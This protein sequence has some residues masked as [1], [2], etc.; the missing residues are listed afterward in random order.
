VAPHPIA[1]GIDDPEF[2]HLVFDA[3]EDG[4]FDGELVLLLHGFPETKRSFRHQLPVLAAL[5]YRV[6]AV[7]QRGYSPS[8][9]PP[10]LDAYRIDKLTGDVL[11]IADSLGADRF[12]LVGHDY[13]AVI[14]WQVAARH[15]GRLLSMTSLSVPHP[16]AYLEAYETS[17]Q[18]ER[19]GYFAWFRDPNTDIELG[20]PQR[21]RQLY[22]AAGLTEDDADAYATALGSPEAIGAALNWYRATGAYMIDG[23]QPITVPVLHVWST[24]DPALGRDGAERTAAHVAGPYR[25]EVLDGVDHWIPENAAD[26]TNRILTDFLTNLR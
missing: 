3:I 5:G 2:E 1:I 24:E 25:F 18:P 4:P 20:D 10:G 11:A 6:V 22:L 12:H 15:Q 8:A 14:A 9:R 21:L 19:S 26:A 16:L 13:G 17:D 23:L 7:D